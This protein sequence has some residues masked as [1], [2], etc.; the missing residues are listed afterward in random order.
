MDGC[1]GAPA[2]AASD[3]SSDLHGSGTVRAES[4]LMKLGRAPDARERRVPWT[5]AR[6]RPRASS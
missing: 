1:R 4:R 2:Q 6:Y 5:E 3:G